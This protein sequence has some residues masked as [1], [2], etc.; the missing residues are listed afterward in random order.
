MKQK[1]SFLAETKLQVDQVSRKKLTKSNKPFIVQK[2][3]FFK[4]QSDHNV[5]R[6]ETRY[7]NL[8]LLIK[9]IGPINIE[10]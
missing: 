3:N 7:N 5:S 9:P 8:E 2:S 10:L 1:H 4:I 6:N